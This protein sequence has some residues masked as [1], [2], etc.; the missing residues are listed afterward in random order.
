M[1]EIYK[2][3]STYNLT[4]MND[5]VE[6]ASIIEPTE[7][8][9]A[10]ER[11]ISKGLGSFYEVGT[12]LGKSTKVGFI[13]TTTKHSKHTARHDGILRHER[14]IRSSIRQG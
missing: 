2:I 11:I 5:E 10:L 6:K 8:L 14:H 3:A 7:S 1:A 13:S 4:T 12:P 9:S